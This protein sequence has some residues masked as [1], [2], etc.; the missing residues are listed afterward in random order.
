MAAKFATVDE[1]VAA[2]PDDVQQILNEIR[3]TIRGVVPDYG[4]RISY[5]MPTA[6][7]AGHDVVYFAAWK[8]HIGMY[9]VPEGD[10]SL[11]QDLAPYR[12]VTSTVR[13][14]YTGPIPY[15]LIGR[16]VALLV[17]QRD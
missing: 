7:Q 10:A 3:R 9:P 6:T 14:P 2:Q 8:R 12:A 17:A 4:E 16:M 11:E 15:G 13:F 1:Y 5:Q